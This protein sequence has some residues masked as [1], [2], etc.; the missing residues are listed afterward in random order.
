MSSRSMLNVG[1][2]AIGAM[3]GAMNMGSSFYGLDDPQDIIGRFRTVPVP[4]QEGPVV[5]TRPESKRARR[6][7]LA[8]EKANG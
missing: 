7:R 8:R 5:D 2:A 6:R 1:L 3:G 4:P